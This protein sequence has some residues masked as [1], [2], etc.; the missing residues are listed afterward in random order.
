M[1]G[2][3][4]FRTKSIESKTMQC[5]F[6]KKNITEKKVAR[7]FAAKGGAAGTGKAKA[8]THEQA[9]KA[10]QARWAK[11]YQEQDKK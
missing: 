11:Y 2:P 3:P 7:H 10:V 5:P 4:G 9:V 8:R 6:C 1:E